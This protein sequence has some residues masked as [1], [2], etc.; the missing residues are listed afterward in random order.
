[1]GCAEQARPDA[2]DGHE[3]RSYLGLGRGLSGVP[4]RQK[5]ARRIDTPVLVSQAGS[6]HSGHCRRGV[7]RGDERPPPPRGGEV[8]MLKHNLVLSPDRRTLLCSDRRVEGGWLEE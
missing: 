1:M 6:R 5:A 3:L 8:G 7:G 2:G 4:R